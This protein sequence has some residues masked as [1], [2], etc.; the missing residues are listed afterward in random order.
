[1]NAHQ[2]HVCCKDEKGQDSKLHNIFGNSSGNK[3]VKHKHNAAIG[4]FPCFK[5]EVSK[6]VSA[7]LHEMFRV[8]LLYMS[9]AEL[10]HHCMLRV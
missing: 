1:M 6:E 2:I 10:R 9:N 7:S 4:V 3:K 5:S 8:V